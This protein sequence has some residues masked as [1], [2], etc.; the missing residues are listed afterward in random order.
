M[1][2]NLIQ[3]FPLYISKSSV[4]DG[5]MRWSAI[6]SD[7][8]WDLYGERMSLEL[9]KSMI[10]KIKR[11][12]PP[13]T[14]FKA[15]VTS[16]YWQGGM[17]Y[18]SIAHYSDGNGKAV[19][20]KVL[21]LF[22]DGKQL[23]S[24]GTLFESDLGQAVWNSLKQ[25]ELNYK[26]AIDADRIRISIAFLDLAHKH[27]NDGEIFQRKS[28]KDLCPQCLEGVGEKVYVDGYLVHLALTRVP[29]NPRTIM[30]IEDIMATK[31]KPKTRKEDAE[32]VLNN[33]ALAD[34]VSQDALESKSDV[35]IEMSE[36]EDTGE[37]GIETPALVEE[38]NTNK[39]DAMEDEE[40]DEEEDVEEKDGK[41]KP[42][43]YKSLTSEDVTLIAESV[44]NL[45]K[46]SQ[47]DTVSP[48]KSALELS[49]DALYNVVEIESKSAL[50]FED[51]LRNIQPALEEVGKQITEVVRST[52][53]VENPQPQSQ[54]NN[55]VLFL[56]QSLTDKVDGVLTEVATLKA[57]ESTSPAMENRVPVPRS[58]VPQVTPQLVN[59]SDV[60]VNPNSVQNVARRSVG[61]PNK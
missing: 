29:V 21:E 45:L 3:E 50:A 6:S 48:E 39:K 40:D 54:V 61:L 5:E 42:K 26:N 11:N 56:L 15:T 46:K 9:Y 7:V 58:I 1:N 14:N 44:A 33:E 52:V 8:E 16:D 59:K 22:I 60:S 19:P 51:K 35:L 13:P 23:K 49:M 41:K 57:R 37:V 12:E 2:N 4:V 32:S 43:S 17:P 27:G 55:D 18:L 10:A 36:A 47:V 34:Q 28:L 53:V 24:K 20:G 31:S 25:D 38:A 30:E